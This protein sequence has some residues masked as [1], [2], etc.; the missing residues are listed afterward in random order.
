MSKE[1]V[2]AML[3]LD[4]WYGDDDVTQIKVKV[5]SDFAIEIG[6]TSMTTDEYHR[7]TEDIRNALNKLVKDIK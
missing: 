3:Y 2:M 6:A 1:D 4:G 7:M 5:T